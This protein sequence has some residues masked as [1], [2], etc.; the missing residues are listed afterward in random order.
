MTVIR[1]VYISRSAPHGLSLVHGREVIL[2]SIFPSFGRL[3]TNKEKVKISKTITA[4][5]LRVPDK[6]VAQAQAPPT[7]ADAKMRTD[8]LAPSSTC[9]KGSQQFAYFTQVETFFFRQFLAE[10]FMHLKE[11]VA[12]L[13]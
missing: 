13:D 5:R 7:D 10:L 6:C 8:Y 12:I 4:N 11:Q 3:L 2:S 1:S 9:P